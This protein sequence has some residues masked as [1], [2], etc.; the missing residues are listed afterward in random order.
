CS[1]DGI[2]AVGGGG[3]VVG[4]GGGVVGGGGG[5][6]GGGS[7]VAVLDG[8]DS[9]SIGVSGTESESTFVVSSAAELVSPTGSADGSLTLS[10]D[11]QEAAKIQHAVIAGN[12][13]NKVDFF[14][15][16]TL[17]YL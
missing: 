17:R 3:G 1:P 11:W 7:G 2:A 8:I 5:V 6:V 10:S 4:G 12:H 16:Q 9:S 14:M 13:P 15:L